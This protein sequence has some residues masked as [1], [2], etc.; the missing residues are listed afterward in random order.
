MPGVEDFGIVPVEAQ[1]AGAPVIALAAGGALETVNG[2]RDAVATGVFFEEPTAH[3]LVE[4]I[5]AFE[6]RAFDPAACRANA[7]R[8]TRPH[9]LHAMATEIETV[10]RDGP[11]AARA[12]AGAAGA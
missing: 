6:E 4:A 2:G 3:A 12:S 8:F 10:M 1:A 9:F 7:L 11:T 5:Q